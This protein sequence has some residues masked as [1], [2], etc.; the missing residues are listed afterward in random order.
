MASS[1]ERLNHIISQ[2]LG[3]RLDNHCSAN[4]TV[5]LWI[6]L[7]YILRKDLKTLSVS[8]PSSYLLS[9][10]KSN[11]LISLLLLG[12]WLSNQRLDYNQHS[13]QAPEATGL[14]LAPQSAPWDLTL[15]NLN[16]L[17]L[18]NAEVGSALLH[19]KLIP[20]EEDAEAKQWWWAGKAWRE[21]VLPNPCLLPLFILL[22][23][24]K[25]CARVE[26]P[27]IPYNL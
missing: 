26:K 2:C 6:Y 9:D 17:G 1:P 13:L 10:I 21:R 7:I 27:H 3:V 12:L 25:T 15:F 24:W 22:S 18:G 8:G 5:P 4:P 11:I 14:T 19:P 20:A 16:L 23:T